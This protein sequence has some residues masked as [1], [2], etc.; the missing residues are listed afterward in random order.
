MAAKPTKTKAVL[1]SKNTAVLEKPIGLKKQ[2]I[3]K[4]FS[5]KNLIVEDI[6]EHSLDIN[7]LL[8]ILT[9]VKN[10]NFDVKMPIHNVGI[11][12]KVCDTLNE[13]ISMNKKLVKE[14]SKARTTIGKE[15][16]LN[17][18]VILPY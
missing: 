18:R 11:S 13:I 17:H 10:G 6:V 3:A 16:K 8:T 7:E 15:G 4:A 12:G 1:N 2:K 9:E 14:F 5:N